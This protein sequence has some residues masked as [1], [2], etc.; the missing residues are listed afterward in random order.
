MQ[1][2]RG[3]STLTSF[4]CNASTF[5]TRLHPWSKVEVYCESNETYRFANGRIAPPRPSRANYSLQ[6]SR[7]RSPQ[8]VVANPKRFRNQ[9]RSSARA[10]P[11]VE[12]LVVD[13]HV[14]RGREL[15]SNRP[16]RE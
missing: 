4:K 5:A 15:D 16:V 1:G 2:S 11:A 12:S 9:L 7:A 8:A 6:S 10:L 13:P 14:R 3:A